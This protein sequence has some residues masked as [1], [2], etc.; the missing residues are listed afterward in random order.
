MS[1]PLL[2][3][4]K[5][6]RPGMERTQS[7]PSTLFYFFH[8]YYFALDLA[9]IV[10]LLFSILA[11][12][13]CLSC[14]CLNPFSEN[15]TIPP[16]TATR[17]P[18]NASHLNIY[19][20]SHPHLS[21]LLFWSFTFDIFDLKTIFAHSPSI[22]ARFYIQAVLLN[23]VC[24]R[25]ST[26][27]PQLETLLVGDITKKSPVLPSAIYTILPTTSLFSRHTLH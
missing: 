21:P 2:V 19:S 13:A 20:R 24:A 4:G 5:N 7:L 18:T 1:Q 12:C 9:L 16:L 25:S 17:P 26:A 11:W 15:Y 10:F 6:T 27:P 8:F 14:A 23:Q 22:I 3:C